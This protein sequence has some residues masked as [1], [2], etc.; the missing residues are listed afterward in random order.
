[1]QK[2]CTQ[3]R[4][5]N[6]PAASECVRCGGVLAGFDRSRSVGGII[7]RRAL[8]CVLVCGIVLAGFYLSLVGSARSLTYD[9]KQIVNR[10]ISLLR[11]RGFT[12]EVFLLEY[13]TVFRSEDNW[14]NASVAK[15]SAYAATNYPFEIITFYEDYFA[16]PRDDVERAAILLHESKHLQGMDEHEAYEY[17]WKHREQ[18]GWTRDRYRDSPVWQN[19]RIQ[20]KDNVPQ[21]F[22]CE[23]NEMADC[24]EKPRHSLID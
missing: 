18:L 19:I 13:V 2:K 20:T 9:Q 15:E 12:D 14:L 16:Y 10:A 23:I 1:M 8:I 22:V 5:V 24:T 11:D 3:C 7:V 6:F 17:V 21:L 4:L